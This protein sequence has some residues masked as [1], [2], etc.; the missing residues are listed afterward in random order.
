[1]PYAVFVGSKPKGDFEVHKNGKDEVWAAKTVIATK[2][3]PSYGRPDPDDQKHEPNRYIC[4]EG[5]WTNLATNEANQKPGECVPLCKVPSLQEGTKYASKLGESSKTV[6]DGVTYV[7]PK[8]VLKVE[9][10]QNYK[11]PEDVKYPGDTQDLDCK[12]GDDGFFDPTTKK[13]NAVPIVCKKAGA[14]GCSP[15]TPASVGPG[16]DVASDKCE[17]KGG[18][19][20]VG[21]TV[22]IKC[23][24][25]YYPSG[26]G[27][28]TPEQQTLKCE[29][30]VNGWVDSNTNT[31]NATHIICLPG[32]DVVEN[33][34]R[35]TIVGT[36][37][38]VVTVGSKKY[39][40]AGTKLK[41]KC[42][43]G[44]VFTTFEGMFN[45]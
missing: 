18:L 32:C 34:D 6:A 1:M 12:G 2:C 22:T 41:I 26:A 29:A 28:K 20:T 30:G 39:H 21:C 24:D 45:Q 38:D 16:A 31:K 44:R 17:I 27:D 5:G 7:Y 25:G 8:T 37:P 43:E 9:C 4:D 40:A 11:P 10:E 14:D 13:N 3:K 42:K 35:A 19:A 33:L 15:I 23:K 36:K